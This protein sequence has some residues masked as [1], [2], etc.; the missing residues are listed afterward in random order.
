MPILNANIQRT[1]VIL[2][3]ACDWMLL[4]YLHCF[5]IFIPAPH[6]PPMQMTRFTKAG[7]N[8]SN[9]LKLWAILFPQFQAPLEQTTPKPASQIHLPFK[10]NP[11]DASDI[12]HQLFYTIVTKTQQIFLNVPCHPSSFTRSMPPPTGCLSPINK[13]CPT[14]KTTSLS[15]NLA[16]YWKHSFIHVFPSQNPSHFLLPFSF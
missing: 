13:S 8:L 5:V 16:F 11:P 6:S 9:S 15:L 10:L 12:S 7:C 3:F 2:P 14:S 4:I 1:Q